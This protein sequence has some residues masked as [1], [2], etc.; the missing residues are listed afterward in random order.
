MPLTLGGVVV[1]TG[2]SAATTAVGGVATAAMPATFE[3]VTSARI[4][5]SMS[6]VVSV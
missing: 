1:L 3:A 2:G 4:V 5:A 6:A